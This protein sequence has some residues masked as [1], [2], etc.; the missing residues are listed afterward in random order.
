MTTTSTAP[1]RESPTQ[2]TVLLGAY[3]ARSC[4]VK[5]HNAYDPTV[6]R[7]EVEPDGALAELFDG[8]AR[9]EAVVLDALIQSCRGRVVDLRLLAAE[10]RSTQV[11]ACRRA[12]SS[13]AQV[14]IGGYLPVDPA[15]HRVG[16][17]DLL[18]RGADAAG[19]PAY[20]P[21]EVKWHKIIER[22]RRP[23]AEGEE[24]PTLRYSTLSDPQP[25]RSDHLV[26]HGLRFASREADF[27]QLAHYFRM[28]QAAG[29]APDHPL[30]AVI[31]TDGLFDQPVLAWVDLGQPAVR[32]FSRSHPEGWR[33]R[34]PLERYDYEHRLRVEI[35]TVA[36][37]RTGDVE[38]DPEPLVQ[39]IVNAECGRCPW[40]EHCRP[41]L[42]PD[43]VSLRIDKGAL[44]LR[45]IATLR[46]HGIAT[47]TDLVGTDLDQLLAT[48]LPEVTHRPG[49]EQRLRMA[50][51]RARMLLAG[52][53]FSRETTGPIELPEAEVEIDFDIE[54]S[55]DGRIYLWGF[56]VRDGA[57]PAT[58]RDFSRFDDLDDQSETAL[59]R[60]AFSWLRSVVDS[61]RPVVVYHYSSYEVAR[62]KEL[63]QR[64]HDGLLEWAAAY[65]EEHFVDLLE[66]VKTHFFG[67]SGLGLKLVAAHAG[68]HWRD[69]D[70]G[71]LNSQ[72]WFADAV[73]ADSP[74][75]RTQAR[76]RVLEYNEDD[77]IATSELRAWLRAQ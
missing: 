70:P 51:R 66:V 23:L 19:R 44:D 43:D 32:T 55:A 8:G 60:Q 26:G 3:A 41:Q 74:A 2:Q 31:G 54:S 6:R 33:L 36:T 29:F 61:G 57:G 20:H 48:Y 56:L 72:R 68:F 45:E 39:P 11:D 53:A 59:A 67:V 21:V 9:F 24:P 40:W 50:A 65:A 71:G 46:R 15:G 62:I 27:V 10:S 63:A 17:P 16:S 77:V 49:A 30:A 13:G 34:S 69:D 38:R 58:Y 4:P 7:S 35:A 1:V 28:L 12:L 76:T 5:T 73:H 22:S 42:H 47:I 52:V 14:I 25:Q 64:E 75:E 37:R 18:V